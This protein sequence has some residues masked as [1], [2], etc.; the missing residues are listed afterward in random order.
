MNLLFIF[1][2]FRMEDIKSTR[3]KT[4]I[5]A[6]F[7]LV[8]FGTLIWFFNIKIRRKLKDICPNGNCS[9][10]G[11]T[12]N[13]NI[14]RMTDEISFLIVTSLWLLVGNIIIYLEYTNFF[15]GKEATVWVSVCS[16]Q[17][18]HLY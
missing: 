17:I 6:T 10:L 1:I 14:A 3:W 18:I 5:R 16:S 7:T 11:G 13:R 4:L 15:E 2:F 9:A 8:I 12:Y